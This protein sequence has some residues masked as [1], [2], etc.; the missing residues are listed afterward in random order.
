MFV[1]LWTFDSLF[2]GFK[3]EQEDA[4]LIIPECIF[5]GSCQVRDPFFY[6]PTEAFLTTIASLTDEALA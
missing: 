5:R 4:R 1:F 6:L 2:L 3:V